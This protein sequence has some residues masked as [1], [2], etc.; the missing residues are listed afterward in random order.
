MDIWLHVIHD[1]IVVTDK[2]P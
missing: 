1:N 2:L